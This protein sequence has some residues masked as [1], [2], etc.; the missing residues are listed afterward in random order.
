MKR[1]PT[2]RTDATDAAGSAGTLFAG[3]VLPPMATA[4]FSWPTATAPTA[5]IPI[6]SARSARREDA[7]VIDLAS[8][9]TSRDRHPSR[10]GVRGLLPR[11]TRLRLVGR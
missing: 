5:A 6:R 1:T 10:G 8:I 3:D 9:E 4:M 11:P 7:D 2:N